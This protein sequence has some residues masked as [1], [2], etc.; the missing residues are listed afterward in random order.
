SMLVGWC[1]AAEIV[2]CGQDAVCRCGER[3]GDCADDRPAD[4]VGGIPGCRGR[5]VSDV[6]VAKM[7]WA[8]RGIPN[9]YRCRCGVLD[10]GATRTKSRL[11]GNH[12]L[13]PPAHVAAWTPRESTS[14][15]A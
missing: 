3:R 12:D 8:G 13:V 11:V 2:F 6:A 5:M 7:E 15:R 10:C 9:V 14:G 1:S 4:V